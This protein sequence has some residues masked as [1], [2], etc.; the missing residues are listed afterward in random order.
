MRPS[1]TAAPT[2]RSASSIRKN[3]RAPGTGRIRR[4]PSSTWS[5]RD[6]NNYEES[7]LLTTLSYFS[8][9]TDHFLENYYL[10]SKRSVEKPIA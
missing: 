5:Q 3:T 7:A 4:S 10:K 6:N 1:A 2:P 9:H 8:H